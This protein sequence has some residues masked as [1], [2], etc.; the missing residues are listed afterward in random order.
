MTDLANSK[1]AKLAK[2]PATHIL[3]HETKRHVLVRY[4]LVLAIFLGYFLFITNKYGAKE[5]IVVAIL[6]WSFFVL[7]TPI[8]DAGF[9]VDF[10][11]RLLTGIR[12]VASEA[13]VWLI[14]IAINVYSYFF[15]ETI[16]DTTKLL[17]LFKHILERPIP[18][19]S[20]IIVSMLGTFVSITFGDEL[21][22]E[23]KHKDRKL[24]KQYRG[25]HK[26]I[27]MIFI[28]AMAFVL[29]DYLLKGLGVE[30]PL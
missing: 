19:W 16:Y 3:R 6:T 20:I 21:L 8:A 28:F 23:V 9:L 13:T 30:L 5:G 18:F 24:H 15:N 7:S 27:I 26:L 11:L 14:A 25:H 29:Y 12:M 1:K 10:P 4:L 22:D 2:I 17:T